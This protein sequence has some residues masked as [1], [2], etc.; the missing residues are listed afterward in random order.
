[1]PLGLQLCSWPGLSDS[2]AGVG[3]RALNGELADV[4]VPPLA[5]VE[6]LLLVSLVAAS[7]IA[8]ASMMLLLFYFT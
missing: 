6:E 1:M 2:F 8:L 5:D 3:S 7:A 4:A